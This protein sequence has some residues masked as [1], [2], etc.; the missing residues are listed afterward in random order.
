M[1]RLLAL[2]FLMVF[3]TPAFARPGGEG[4]LDGRDPGKIVEQRAERQR[5]YEEMRE[6]RAALRR[7]LQES[8]PTNSEAVPGFRDEATGRI[9]SAAET[10]GRDTLAAPRPVPAKIP[11]TEPATSTGREWRSRVL[12]TVLAILA[13]VLVTM[14]ALRPLL[15]RILA[16]WRQVT[17]TSTSTS[18]MTVSLRPVHER[19][20]RHARKD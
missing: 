18:T 1:M 2:L 4:E 10:G 11:A 16:R 15:L 20:L 17:T 12:L 14:V 6:K 7:E 9:P 13:I 19:G 8:L 3:V 5:R